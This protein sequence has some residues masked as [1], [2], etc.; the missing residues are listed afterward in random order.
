[1]VLSKNKSALWRTN[2][3]LNGKDMKNKLRALQLG[4]LA[5]FKLLRNS[6]KSLS[7]CFNKRMAQFKVMNINSILCRAS[8][9]K[10]SREALSQPRSQ[11]KQSGNSSTNWKAMHLRAV[12][13][14]R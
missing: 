9:K 4:M 10:R 6:F 7:A 2:Y 13:T 11:S 3:F 8:C 14:S 1:M 12:S 5:I